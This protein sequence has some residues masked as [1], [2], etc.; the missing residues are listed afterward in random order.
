MALAATPAQPRLGGK[1]SCQQDQQAK[2]KQ[3]YHPPNELGT[4]RHVP[5]LSH[6]ESGVKLEEMPKRGL[7]NP[8]QS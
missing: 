1:L 6:F 5:C 7:S 4:L 3:P 2:D 8:Q